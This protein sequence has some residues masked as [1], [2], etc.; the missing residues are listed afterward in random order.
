MKNKKNEGNANISEIVFILDRSGSMHGLEK[1]TIGGFNSLIAKQKEQ[2]GSCFV[3]TVLFDNELQTVHDRLPLEKVPE[4]TGREYYTR[5]CTALLDAIGETVI[6]IETIHKYA[7]PDDVPGRTM[8]VII[9]DGM[10]NASKHFSHSEIKRLIEKKKEA[11]SWEFLFIG[12]NID[13]VTTAGHLGIDAEN[14]VN[15][16]A[17]AQGTEVVYSAVCEAVGNVRARAPL[18][19]KWNKKINDDFKAR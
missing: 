4:M 14:S 11:D 7:R 5:G 16:H 8:F 19:K 15:Y 18:G 9:T 12:A 6:H 17:D 10:E 3:T 1:D 13:A 2:P